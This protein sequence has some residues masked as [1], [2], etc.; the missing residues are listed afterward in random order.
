MKNSHLPKILNFS[1]NHNFFDNF[2]KDN[3]ENKRILNESWTICQNQ[4]LHSEN[5]KHQKLL[6]LVTPTYR[7]PEQ[8]AEL[9]RLLQTLLHIQPVLHWIIVE[10]ARVCS[11]ELEKVLRRFSNLS[12][13]RIAAPTPLVFTVSLT[14]TNNNPNNKERLSFPCF[15][16]YNSGTTRPIE[17]KLCMH[18]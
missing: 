4:F 7:R 6:F 2:P 17:M 8:I 11:P 14:C 3:P 16:P 10:D 5:S 18:F 12:F 13:T 1:K 9:T 15:P